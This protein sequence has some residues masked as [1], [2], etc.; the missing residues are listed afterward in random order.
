MFASL[1]SCS[2]EREALRRQR[3]IGE[4]ETLTYELEGSPVTRGAVFHSRPYTQFAMEREHGWPLDMVCLR[5]LVCNI[6][7]I[8]TLYLNDLVKLCIK[9]YHS[10]E[11]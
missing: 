2:E 3:C 10:C 6:L 5:V 9:G 1:E 11:I 4:R 7:M 8:F